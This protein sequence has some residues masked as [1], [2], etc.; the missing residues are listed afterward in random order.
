MNRLDENSHVLLFVGPED[1]TT[2]PFIDAAQAIY[3]V[4]VCADAAPGQTLPRA[5]L[6][7]VHPVSNEAG[8]AL[9]CVKLL[10]DEHGFRDTP[11]LVMA[12]FH[13][14]LAYT[15]L[16]ESGVRDIINKPVQLPL[17]MSRLRTQMELLFY[18]RLLHRETHLDPV[19]GVLNRHSL[20][21]HLR[22][23][24]S[25][26]R[27]NRK[28]V[29]LV[30]ICLDHLESFGALYGREP[31]ADCMRL[32]AAGL[33][34]IVKR[35]ADFVARYEDN[36]FVTLLPETDA[37][38]ACQIA[39]ALRR[40]VE[41]LE[42]KNNHEQA[43]AGKITASLGVATGIPQEDNSDPNKLVELGRQALV[44]AQALGRNCIASF[45]MPHNV[46]AG[47]SNAPNA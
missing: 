43:E 8:D 41:A 35:P 21:D 32:V 5:D 15:A 40:K 10:R 33:Q 23:E 16:F 4:A 38:A 30:F 12:P 26:A 44:D 29:S 39:E 6:V 45:I 25:R 28:P 34:S 11:I 36:T 2:L 46:E 3:Q 7:V 1:E 24:W 19:T 31:L 42:I 22:R 9:A 17:A 37:E 47:K 27:R 20:D 18:R 14:D 13:A